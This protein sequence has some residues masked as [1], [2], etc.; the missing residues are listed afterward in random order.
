MLRMLLVISLTVAAG[1]AA[2]IVM[3]I[4]TSKNQF[5]V[6]NRTAIV[7]GGS[8]GLGLALARQLSAKGANVVIVAQTVSK[9]EKALG[10]VRDAASNPAIQKFMYLSYDLRSPESAP[11]IL[12]KVTEW[13]SAEPPDVVLNCAG[14]CIPSFFAS[15]STDTLRDQMDTLYWSCAYVA[16]ATLRQWIQPVKKQVQKSYDNKPRHLIFTSSVLAFMPLA[17]YAPYNPAKAAMR[18]LA[19]T[20]NQEVQ[21]Y[22]GARS[23]PIE[24]GPAAEIK[25]HAVFPAGILSPGYENEQKSKPALT[26]K[27]EEDDKPQQPEELATIII[28]ELEAGKYMITSL[29]VGH[30]L[31]GF[32]FGPSTRVGLMDYVWNCLGSIIVLFIVPDFTSKCWKWGKTNGLAGAT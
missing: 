30:L 3:G 19:D 23:H 15:A 25:V 13:N 2:Y 11:A 16:H 10:V 7:T 17:G 12:A 32:G 1:I 24:P 27:L 29:F 6:A 28:S 31:K 22:N 20:L 4:F 21:V 5:D 26:R 8:Q 18:T 9:L 14:L